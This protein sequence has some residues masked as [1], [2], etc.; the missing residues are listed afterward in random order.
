[1]SLRVVPSTPTY[2]CVD[3]GAGTPVTES[4]IE[5]AQRYRGKRVR[6]LLGKRDVRMW[7]NGQPVEVTPGPD[8]AGFAFTPRRSRELPV[9]QRPC[10]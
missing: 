10:E 9:G 7:M 8:P 5:E 3:H 1:V 4:T 2:V 6:I